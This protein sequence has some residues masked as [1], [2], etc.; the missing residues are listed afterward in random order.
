M[1]IECFLE[2]NVFFSNQSNLDI[3]KGL[4]S[5]INQKRM[6]KVNLSKK[7]FRQRADWRKNFATGRRPRHPFFFDFKK[8]QL[9]LACKFNHPKL[10]EYRWSRG[11]WVTRNHF[12]VTRLFPFDLIKR[13][14]FPSLCVSGTS[15]RT[16]SVNNL[17]RRNSD[18]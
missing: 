1:E 7:M 16:L 11:G 13:D 8:T 14:F 12:R 2:F 17:L 10:L 3:K 6:S 18:F 15:Q 4:F 5:P 9:Y